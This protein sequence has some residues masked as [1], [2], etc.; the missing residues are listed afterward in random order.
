[1]Y[2]KGGYELGFVPK[3]TLAQLRHAIDKLPGMSVV[4]GEEEIMV[5]AMHKARRIHTTDYAS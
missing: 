1:M 3:K 2:Q 4:L 5:T